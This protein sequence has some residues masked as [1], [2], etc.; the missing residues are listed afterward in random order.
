VETISKK[1]IYSYEWGEMDAIYPRD[2]GC[3]NKVSL[4]EE[5]HWWSYHFIL[6]IKKTAS[7]F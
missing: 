4:I 1:K 2:L 7:P 5:L 3:G 6:L